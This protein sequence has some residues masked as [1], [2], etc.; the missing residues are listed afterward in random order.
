MKKWLLFISLALVVL[1]AVLVPVTALAADSGRSSIAKKFSVTLTPASI[2]D[3]VLGKVW[4]NRDEAS[5]NVW[6]IQDSTGIV[7][8]IIDGRS[9][10][11]GLSGDIDGDFSFTYGGVLDVLQSGS[12]QGVVT[13]KAGRPASPDVIH[14]AADG[15]LEAQVKAYYTFGEIQGWWTVVRPGTPV[16]YLLSRVYSITDLEGLDDATLQGMYGV[17]LP[18]LPKTLTADFSGTVRIDA[19]TGAYAG[20]RGTGQFGSGKQLLTLSVFPDQHVYKI[21]GQIKLTGTYIKQTPRRIGNIDREKL[22]DAI[23][24]IRGNPGNGNSGK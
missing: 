17:T 7:G 2:D 6:P 3:T 21:D 20:S 13:L 18:P 5:T 8:W 14:M 24:K 1:V 22:K 15:E 11:G 10:R 16:G 12:I 4:P 9:I 19:G 23:D